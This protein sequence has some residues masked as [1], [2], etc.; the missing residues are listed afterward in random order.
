MT[1][2]INYVSYNPSTVDRRKLTNNESA[3][4]SALSGLEFA[5]A[6]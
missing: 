1:G 3:P 5:Q 4:M 2:G 6:L